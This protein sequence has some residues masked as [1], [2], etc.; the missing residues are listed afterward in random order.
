MMEKAFQEVEIRKEEI[1]F[2]LTDFKLIL[3][4]S[5]KEGYF[6]LIER[7]IHLEDA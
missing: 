5:H 4:S 2:V 3:V 7:K 1:L 6:I